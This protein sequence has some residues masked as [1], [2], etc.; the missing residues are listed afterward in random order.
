MKG[1][2]STTEVER[3]DVVAAKVGMRLEYRRDFDL[4]EGFGHRSILCY[5]KIAKSVVRLP[6][7][8][9]LAQHSPLA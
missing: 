5:R 3:G 1:S 2:P 7:R 6:R 4:P 8:E 9:G